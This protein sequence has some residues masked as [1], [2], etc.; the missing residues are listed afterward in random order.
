MLCV[1]FI[2]V[3]LLLTAFLSSQL[4]KESPRF[5]VAR[6]RHAEAKAVLAHIAFV[7]HRPPFSYRL[8]GELQGRQP[9]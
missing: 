6:N 5:L 2:G 8:E 3:P 9:E 4:L 1:F 7:N